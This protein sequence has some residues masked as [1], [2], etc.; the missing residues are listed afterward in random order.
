MSEPAVFVLIAMGLAL[1]A[2]LVFALIEEQPKLHALAKVFAAR[3]ARLA[4]HLAS[5]TNLAPDSI[6]RRVVAAM[7]FEISAIAAAAA[8]GADA[9]AAQER[10]LTDACGDVAAKVSED[11]RR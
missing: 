3:T 6:A 2:G 5:A 4:R 10:R 9:V 11:A 1:G 8:T 7:R